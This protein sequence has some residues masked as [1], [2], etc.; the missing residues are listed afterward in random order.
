MHNNDYGLRS[1][2]SF[3]PVISRVRR[4]GLLGFAALCGLSSNIEIFQAASAHAEPVFGTPVRVTLVDNPQG[5]SITHDGKKLYITHGEYVVSVF[6]TE[7]KKVVD[8]V[9]GI[10][11]AV[12]SNSVAISPDDKRAYVTTMADRYSWDGTVSV[13]DTANDHIVGT[14]PVGKGAEGIAIT[15]DGKKLYV[16]SIQADYLSIIDAGSLKLTKKIPIGLGGQT[17][18][19]SP[20]GRKIYVGIVDDKFGD[21]VAVID[22]AS[23]TVAQKIKIGG[24]PYGEAMS[25]D[26]RRLYVATEDFGVAVIDTA[27]SSLIT[28]IPAEDFTG[29]GAHGVVVSKDGKVLYVTHEPFFVTAFDTA[30]FRKLD[31]VSTGGNPF[32]TVVA[33]DGKTLY[34]ATSGQPARIVPAAPGDVLVSIPIHQ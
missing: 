29:S 25:P 18:V 12:A 9:D 2:R 17:A 31:T 26:G 8:I 28:V 34:V 30:T 6:D 11:N 16:A 14:V 23:D 3:R 10:G 21:S 33:P 4:L 27:S 7:T 24:H 32:G 19:A 15:P 22:T 13:I 1:W 5:L 20:D